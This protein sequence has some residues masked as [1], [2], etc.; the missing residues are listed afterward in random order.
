MGLRARMTSIRGKMPLPVLEKTTS[1]SLKTMRL[2][3]DFSSLFRY[4]LKPIHVL[5]DI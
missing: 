1:P 2:A 4:S 3:P 5:P